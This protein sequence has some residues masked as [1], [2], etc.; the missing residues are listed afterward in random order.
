[1]LELWDAKIRLHLLIK[2]KD[3]KKESQ[4]SGIDQILRI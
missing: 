3:E 4:V 2:G 1:M